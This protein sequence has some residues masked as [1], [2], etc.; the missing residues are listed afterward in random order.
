MRIAFERVTTVSPLIRLDAR[1]RV[2]VTLALIVGV[3]LLPTPVVTTSVTIPATYA[4]MLALLIGWMRAGALDPL[5]VM[6]RAGLVLPFTLA[7]A[8]LLFTTPGQRLGGLPIT[9]AGALRFVA[10]VLKAWLSAQAALALTQTTPFLDLIDAL[11]G[12]GVPRVFVVIVQFTYRYLDVLGDEAHRLIRA[13][14][15]RSASLGGRSGGSLLWRARVTG[16]MVGSLFLRSY[17]RAERIQQAMAARG[18]R[19][20]V[21]TR[22][23]PPLDWRE[24]I[25]A[26]I[27]LAL[28]VAVELIARL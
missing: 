21:P 16:Q 24:S 2:V 4:L 19:G 7:A 18:Y 12:L 1:V 8:T 20:D 26:F 3:G 22:T 10:V 6:R 28:L 15:S 17:E 27:P 5:R 9:D 25:W 11:H 23:L 14:A 13:R